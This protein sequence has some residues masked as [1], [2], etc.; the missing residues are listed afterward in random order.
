MHTCG[1]EN[2]PEGMNMCEGVSM[3]EGMN[4]CI[5]MYT[6]E[7]CEVREYTSVKG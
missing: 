7:S 4:N 5:G 6:S 1:A 3:C 2:T